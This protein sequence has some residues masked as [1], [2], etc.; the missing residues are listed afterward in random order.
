MKKCQFVSINK[1]DT[2]EKL[3]VK[4]KSSIES[5]QSSNPTVNF[6]QIKEGQMICISSELSVCPIGSIPYQVKDDDTLGSIATKFYTTVE[7]IIDTNPNIDPNN[8]QIGQ[9]ICINEQLPKIPTCPSMNI[10]VIRPQDTLYSI[11]SKFGITIDS[12]TRINKGLNPYNLS[13]GSIICLPFTPTPY[14]IVIEVQLKRLLLYYLGRLYT[15]YPVAVGKQ[16][17]PTPLGQFYI[18]N[19]QVNP[20]GPFGTRWM[21]LSQPSYGIHGTNRPDS[22]GFNA[23]NGCIR[24]FNHDVEDLFSKVSVQTPVIIL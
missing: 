12:L 21:G 15:N 8:L 20:G 3:A 23:S 11:A 22:I 6:N 19:K 14:I 1:G 13:V 4:Y 10:Y 17:T 16:T 5:V 9:I 18:L 24:M 2:L 7:T